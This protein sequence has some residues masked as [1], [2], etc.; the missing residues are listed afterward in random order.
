METI[1]SSD[2]SGIE[3]YRDQSNTKEKSGA[4]PQ[5]PLHDEN[6]RPAENKDLL[7]QNRDTESA[8]KDDSNVEIRPESSLL[9]TPTEEKLLNGSSNSFSQSENDS[10]KRDSDSGSTSASEGMD[11]SISLSAD[12]SLN[13][14]SGSLS[15][16]VRIWNYIMGLLFGHLFVMSHKLAL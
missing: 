7:H 15:L 10:L 9:E 6:R 12:L 14:G 1:S 8:R 4:S 16:K 3:H 11:L 2:L 5:L 13:R